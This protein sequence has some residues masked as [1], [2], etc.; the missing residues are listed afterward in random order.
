MRDAAANGPLGAGAVLVVAPWLHMM[1][2]AG[3]V[4]MRRHAVSTV[5]LL[6][7]GHLGLE[8]HHEDEARA[9]GG[10][11]EGWTVGCLVVGWE[12]RVF[13]SRAR[14]RA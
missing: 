4:S 5:A 11:M 9:R 6:G 14:V 3:P 12:T 1:G 2:G 8:L 10:R 13:A 7:G